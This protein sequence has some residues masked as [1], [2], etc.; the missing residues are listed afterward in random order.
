MANIWDSTVKISKSGA[1][2]KDDP[3]QLRAIAQELVDIL[4]V[5]YEHFFVELNSDQS[6]SVTSKWE[7]HD[8]RHDLQEFSSKHPDLTFKVE[9]G[10]DV[11]SDDGESLN[12]E[13][14]QVINGKVTGD[15][16]SQC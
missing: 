14:F 1:T 12:D 16:E 9:A 15:T 8:L 6:V 4:K 3:K 11:E 10:G 5:A 7:Y 2:N 13:K